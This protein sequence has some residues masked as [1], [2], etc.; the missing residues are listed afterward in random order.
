M[1]SKGKVFVLLVCGHSE[2]LSLG[3]RMVML[4]TMVSWCVRYKAPT[5]Y[6]LGNALRALMR[7]P[8]GP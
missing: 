2:G 7:L 3:Q 1:F 6:G 8:S 5:H 4:N